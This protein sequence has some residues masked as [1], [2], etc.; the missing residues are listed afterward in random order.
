MRSWILLALVGCGATAQAPA[1]PDLA[2]DLA[3]CDD[4]SDA[5]YA[6]IWPDLL[7]PQC[8]GCHN[9]SGLAG[10]ASPPARLLFELNNTSAALES[11][12]ENARMV[13]LID[14]QDESVL[15]EKPTGAVDHG[16]GERFDIDSGSYAALAAWVEL[17]RTDPA[18]CEEVQEPVPELIFEPLLPSAAAWKTANHLL[19]RPPTSE[20]IAAYADEPRQ[21]ALAW[22]ADPAFEERV[23]QMWN[24]V[25]LTRAY[26]NNGSDPLRQIRSDD[27]P[28]QTVM[29]DGIPGYERKPVNQALGEQPLELVAYIVRNG[30]PFSELLTADYFMVNDLLVPL[31]DAELVDHGGD[32]AR[33]WSPARGYISPGGARAPMPHV[34]VINHAA[35]LTRHP[36]NVGN[37]H[38]GRIAT[39]FKEFLGVDVF[40]LS[41]RPANPSSTEI[42]NPV[43]NDPN[44]S[45]CH[46]VIDPPAAAFAAYSM[47]NNRALDF[48]LPAEW[49]DDL[50]PPGFDGEP[51]V[52][53][54]LDQGLGWLATRITEDPRFATAVIDRVYRN[55]VGRSPLAREGDLGT[56]AWEQE[57]AFLASVGDTWLNSREDL[58]EVIAD[59]VVSPW[60][61][62]ASARFVVD[63]ADAGP[64]LDLGVGTPMYPEQ[65]SAK[66]TTI[67]DLPEMGWDLTELTLFGGIDSIATVE[68]IRATSPVAANTMWDASYELACASVARDFYRP[69]DE[70]QLFPE[71][72][73]TDDPLDPALEA[74]ARA[75]I[76]QM[77]AVL[78]GQTLSA[79]DPTVDRLYTLLLDAVESGRLAVDEDGAPGWLANACRA[80][81]GETEIRS[82]RDYIVRGWM[83][84][85]ATM[86]SDWRFTHE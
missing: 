67:L 59:I 5:F 64:A 51:L 39:L 85:L 6:T 35:W 72:L 49:D 55:L 26:V 41:D 65:L 52:A 21:Q 68:R 25:L 27:F 44:C 58:R 38:R 20:E 74:N 11:N 46:Q 60:F 69:M 50:F 81:E 56:V 79:S 37:L 47:R 1:E 24:D 22:I 16:G 10:Q 32:A 61:V 53:E 12:F 28:A 9:P 7:Q 33:G 48:E 13:A 78:Y 8:S 36:T 40:D 70:R 29:Y 71:L 66:A 83:T 15:L 3:P 76:V 62:S 18:D 4:P 31:F 75:A 30:R 63:G 17:A 54:E 43:V 84:V 34:G 86:L 45:V 14:G 77:S 42:E 23:K 73:H 57:Q 2:V 82:D 80:G 19:G